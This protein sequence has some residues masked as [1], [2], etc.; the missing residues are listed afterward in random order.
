M[1][2]DLLAINEDVKSQEE[3]LDRAVRIKSD[4]KN[5]QREETINE[6][7]LT[8]SKVASARKGKDEKT[9]QNHE[10]VKAVEATLDAANK[11]KGEAETN[12][13]QK[14]QKYI[15]ELEEKDFNYTSEIAN[16]LGDEY[17][18]GVSQEN[19]VTRDKNDLPIKI[20]TRRIVVKNGRGEVYKRIQNKSGVT[21]SK[22]GSPISEMSWIKA[23]E[24][25]NLEKH[26]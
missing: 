22:N 20:V 21:Y 12:E 3:L 24:N 5:K 25:A 2:E 16:S 10:S 6:I 1:K 14:T 8:E 15:E 13:K 17:P 7:D 19:F 11:L 26:Y 23:T 18:E 9:K 4:E